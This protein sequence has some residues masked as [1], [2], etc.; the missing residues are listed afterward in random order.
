MRSWC[1]GYTI[2]LGPANQNTA[3]AGAT[4]TGQKS[5]SVR[6]LTSKHVINSD[7]VKV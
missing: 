2:R 6:F 4:A 7:F 3:V 1:D 5:E